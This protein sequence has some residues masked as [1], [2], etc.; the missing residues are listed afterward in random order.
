MRMVTHCRSQEYNQEEEQDEDTRIG[1]S[2]ANFVFVTIIVSACL[3][4]INHRDS[5]VEQLPNLGYLYLAY[6]ILGLIIGFTNNIAALLFS[7]AAG[8]CYFTF[9]SSWS[10]SLDWSI[11]AMTS[12]WEWVSSF[13]IMLWHWVAWG[14]IHLWDGIVWLVSH[15]WDGIVWCIVGLWKCIVFFSYQI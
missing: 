11:Y 5:I 15:L 12:I 2:I 9:L 1:T 13:F 6:C 8:V 4:F 14:A 7:I 10:V 3:F